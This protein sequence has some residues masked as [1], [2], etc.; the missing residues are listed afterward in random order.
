[1]ATITEVIDYLNQC[2]SDVGDIDVVF[3]DDS[4]DDA[5]EY[6]ELRGGMFT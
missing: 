3:A 2:L 4:L 1:M 5:T 6:I